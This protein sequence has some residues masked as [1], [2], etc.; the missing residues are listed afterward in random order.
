MRRSNK[1]ALKK[2]K[3]NMPPSYEDLRQRRN[4]LQARAASQQNLVDQRQ[5]RVDEQSIVAGDARDLVERQRESSSLRYRGSNHRPAL[6]AARVIGRQR[7]AGPA[8]SMQRNLQ[9]VLSDMERAELDRRSLA[10]DNA[11]ESRDQA[12]RRA[13]LTENRMR[14]I[15]Q[16]AAQSLL[17]L[18][19]QTGGA[20]VTP[21]TM[22]VA[23]CRP[24]WSISL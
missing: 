18:S 23:R 12:A 6:G 16:D 11:Q 24:C 7:S 15:E 17:R 13:V 10:R 14:Q 5:Q 2:K 8:S 3:Q 20:F 19:E 4:R 1:M 21:L 22:S 9:R